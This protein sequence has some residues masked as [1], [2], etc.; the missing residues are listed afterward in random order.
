MGRCH[1]AHFAKES[2]NLTA[3]SCANAVIGFN[4]EA[5]FAGI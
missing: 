4:F 2:L 5:F 1:S 3:Y